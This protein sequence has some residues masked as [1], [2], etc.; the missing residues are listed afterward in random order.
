M[1]LQPALIADAEERIAR[2]AAVNHG[3]R[4]LITYFVGQAVGQMNTAQPAAQVVMNMV[5]GYIAA[6]TALGESV[7]S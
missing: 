5:E 2:G 3:A 4:Q 1:P 7:A 6:A